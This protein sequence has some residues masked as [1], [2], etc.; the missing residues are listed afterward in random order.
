MVYKLSERVFVFLHT[1]PQACSFELISCT[2]K[3][4]MC[5]YAPVQIKTIAWARKA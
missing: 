4:C 1:T 2:S 3:G 5:V